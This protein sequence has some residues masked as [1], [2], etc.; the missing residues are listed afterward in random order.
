MGP[1]DG[2]SR[3]A[4][5]LGDPL[6]SLDDEEDDGRDGGREDGGPRRGGPLA[7]LRWV[8]LAVV[9]VVAALGLG[10][11]LAF[12]WQ[13]VHPSDTTAS[14]GGPAGAAGAGATGAG[15]TGAGATPTPT[16]AAGAPVKEPVP[17]SWT[18]VTDPVQKATLSHPSTWKERRDNTGIFFAEP[19]ATATGFGPQMVGLARIAGKGP[20]QAL[21]SVQASEFAN[22][23]GY[24]QERFGAVKGGDGASALEFAATY[25]REG[26]QVEYVMR[27]VQSRDATYV[28]MARSTAAPAG[29]AEK[30]L[31]ILTASFTPA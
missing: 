6:D 30:A 20:N 26:Q 14:S 19:A 18:A 28:L 24:H 4:G 2:R 8:A 3:Q 29:G 17:A 5:A 16:G 10:I 31:R 9:V 12:G 13:R 1:D 11:G 15:A 22:L 25:A 7:V 27:A 23:S 21:Q